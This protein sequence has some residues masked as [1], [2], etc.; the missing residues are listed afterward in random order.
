MSA[1]S[2]VAELMVYLWLLVE[3]LSSSIRINCTP[4]SDVFLTKV[5]KA[6]DNKDEGEVVGA[7]L[8]HIDSKA[9]ITPDKCGQILGIMRRIDDAF[10]WIHPRGVKVPPR[11]SA[12]ASPPPWL[13]KMR[14][15]RLR[16]G[17][18]ASFDGRRLVP[19]GPLVRAHRNEHA[20]NAEFLGEWFCSL[21]VTKCVY[22]FNGAPLPI[23]QKVIWT[24][25]ARGIPSANVDVV[26]KVGVLSIA[27]LASDI[28]IS[29][30]R[31]ER[32]DYLDFRLTD[33]VDG[34]DRVFQSL[35]CC[36]SVDIAIAPEF[37]LREAH[38]KGVA[39]R[40]L[41]IDALP[42]FRLFVA[43]S[44]QTNAKI[45]GQSL[46]ECTG[47]NQLG[48]TLFKQCK[49]WPAAMDRT[50]A[51]EL[52]VNVDGYNDKIFEDIASGTS[53]EVVDV[54]SMG[55]CIVLIC[56][57]FKS[58]LAQELIVDFQPDWVFVPILDVGVDPGRWMHQRAFELS[59]HSP[60]RFVIACSTSW[61]KILKKSTS[62]AM[63]VSSKFGDENSAA[64]GIQLGR[65]ESV[66]KDVAVIDWA[67][68]SSWD[69]SKLD[70][71]EV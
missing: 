58:A 21:V 68:A 51:E 17:Y 10:L 41:D 65:N 48:A 37:T 69:Q 40:L 25:A 42:E 61:A 29:P 56:Q 57:D 52:G 64:R 15:D 12:T 2:N 34:V 45:D 63:C 1:P 6:L 49:I 5:D 8:S 43:G 60:A 26:G 53:I 20:G 54:D 3:P 9:R 16:Q 4:A 35:K 39:E 31:G 47:L 46:N 23:V 38:V 18:Y 24:D 33:D 50:R 71:K 36:G 13:E 11:L 55:R 19:K 66:G 44:G 32:N 7:L 30:R 22:I 27:E 28:A 14:L 59:E 62:F 70:I 67:T